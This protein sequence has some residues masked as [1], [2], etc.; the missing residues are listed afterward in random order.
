[1]SYGVHMSS[2]CLPS[3]SY[4]VSDDLYDL[5]DVTWLSHDFACLSNDFMFSYDIELVVQQIHAVFLRTHEDVLWFCRV[6]LRFRIVFV[7]FCTVLLRFNMVLCDLKL[8]AYD[9]FDAVRMISYVCSRSHA[10]F[11]WFC[12]VSNDVMF[13]CDCMCFVLL[14]YQ[15][16]KF[17]HTRPKQLPKTVLKHIELPAPRT[18]IYT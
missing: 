3:I 8:C 7:I 12:M 16:W 17:P 13:S 1:M 18:Y 9:L 10:V 11:L 4:C 2:F 15:Y 5:F 14:L 6:C